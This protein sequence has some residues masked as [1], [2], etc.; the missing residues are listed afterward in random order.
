M[1][2]HNRPYRVRPGTYGKKCVKK[3]ETCTTKFWNQCCDDGFDCFP[4]INL[5]ISDWRKQVS[6]HRVCTNKDEWTAKYWEFHKVRDL[7]NLQQP[8][9]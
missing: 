4:I 1:K 2:G 5:D 6:K 8:V 7:S 9:I 3:G